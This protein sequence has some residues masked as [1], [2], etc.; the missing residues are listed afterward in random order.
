MAM[1][2]QI[3]V[4]EDEGIVAKD[5]QNRLTNMGYH[6]PAVT[7]T[8]EDA[9]VKAEE[10]KPD[11]VLMDIMLKGT[12]DGVTAADTI[13]QKF[14]IPVI[15]VT[16]YSDQNTL[17]RAKISEPFGYLLK[18][19][20]ERELH[21][22][23]EM[24]LYKHKMELKLRESE[25]WLS[26]TLK[27]IGDAVIA[28]DRNGRIAFINPAAEQITGWRRNE[29][30]GRELT[31]IFNV[32][33]EKTRTHIE[34]PVV[35]ILRERTSYKLPY[36][37]NLIAKD[38]MEIPVDDSA[39]PIIDDKGNIIGIVLSFRDITERKMAESVLRQHAQ[40]LIKRVKEL[41][42]LYDIFHILE[43]P[44]GTMKELIDRCMKVVPAAWQY[45]EETCLR[46]RVDGDEYISDRFH[47]TPWRQSA[48]IIANNDIIGSIEVYFLSEKPEKDEGP[49]LK[50]ERNL[51]DAIALEIGHLSERSRLS[52]ALAGTHKP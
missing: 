27:S 25:Q 45:P 40:Y 43:K 49:F 22:T 16:A 11:L 9:I 10:F 14:N 32:I 20:E 26:I 13:R 6:V 23:I 52:E 37:T 24:A 51:L 7:A 28:T 34:S 35:K 44:D 48:N 18:P 17:D 2:I 36:N 19:F 8:G 15:Y 5:I 46:I 12:M 21:S 29:V 47:E 33:D 38:G 50:E 4:V 3:L 42:C 31:D 30:M 39:S 41:N 1:E